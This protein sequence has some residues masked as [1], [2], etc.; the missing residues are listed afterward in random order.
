LKARLIALNLV[1]IGAIVAVI[2]AA[3]VQWDQ[4]E[5][6]R[7]Q[8]LSAAVKAIKTPPPAAVPKPQTAPPAKYADVATKDLFSKDRNPNVV[9]EPP[10]VEKPKPMPS[11]PVV[12]GVLG[13][14]S[15]IKAIMAEKKGA[16]SRP[17]QKGDSI[18]EFKIVSLDTTN[19]VFDWEGQQVARKLDDLVDR[20]APPA[21]ASS[22]PAVA[23]GPAVTAGPAAAPAAP[24]AGNPGKAAPGQTDRPCVAGDKSPNGTVADGYKLSFTD[25]P[26]GR[27][28]CHWSPV[29]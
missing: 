8:N 2:W 13:L 19:V 27:I 25:S 18:G 12:Y 15:G 3:R 24:P 7:T 16:E 21:T 9:I 17:V 10:K 26:F 28:N 1:L 23:A 5:A 4:A 11:L 14:P 22:G 29:Q 6:R 20:S